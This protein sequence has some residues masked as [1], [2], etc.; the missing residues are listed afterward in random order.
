MQPR[1]EVC[2]KNDEYE[3]EQQRSTHVG[4]KVIEMHPRHTL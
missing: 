1:R 4:S 2:A 3:R